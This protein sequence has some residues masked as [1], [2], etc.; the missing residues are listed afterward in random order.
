VKEVAKFFLRGRQWQIFLLL[1]VVPAIAE[2]W[3]ITV[4]PSRIRSWH[5]F[6][7]GGFFFLAV[8]MFY[9]LCFLDGLDP[10]VSF[11]TLCEPGTEDENRAFSLCS[12]LPRAYFPIFLSLVIPDGAIPVGVQL[13]LHLVCIACFVYLFHFVAKNLVMVKIKKHAPP[14]KYW[15]RFLLLFPPLGVWIIQP[16]VNRL[17]AQNKPRIETLGNLRCQYCRKPYCY[18]LQLAWWRISEYY[19]APRQTCPARGPGIGDHGPDSE[20]LATRYHILPLSL[21]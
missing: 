15:P 11:F 6:G 21:R 14:N 2:F 5:D 19:M 1:F 12:G 18:F 3:A 17:Y 8:M 16:E 13:F 4:V 7:P 20:S 10:W 9:L